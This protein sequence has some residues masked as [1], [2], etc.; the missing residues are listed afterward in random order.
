MFGNRPWSDQGCGSVVAGLIV[1]GVAIAAAI[2][3]QPNWQQGLQNFFNQQQQQQNAGPGQGQGG[4]PGGAGP[5]TGGQLHDALGDFPDSFGTGGSA[6]TSVSGE[7]TLSGQQIVADPI[8]SYIQGGEAWL[9]FGDMVGGTGAAEIL[10]TLNESGQDTVTVAQGPLAAIGY[11]DDCRWAITVTASAISGTVACA[12][13]EVRRDFELTG[14][15]SSIQLQ[16]SM[17]LEPMDADGAP[18]GEPPTE[19]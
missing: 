19:N 14:G 13:V 8:Q 15:T 2:A 18:P 6:T 17:T 4:Q 1:V 5:L 3:A 12:S 10:V 16:F 11:D 7:L 9:G